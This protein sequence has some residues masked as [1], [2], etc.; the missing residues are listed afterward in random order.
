MKERYIIIVG[1]LFFSLYG[2]NSVNETEIRN[3]YV[4][5]EKDINIENFGEH[6]IKHVNQAKINYN[7]IVKNAALKNETNSAKCYIEENK[8]IKVDINN[9]KGKD[10]PVAIFILYDKFNF[11][12]IHDDLNTILLDN[13]EKEISIKDVQKLMKEES[14]FINKYEIRVIENNG[15]IEIRFF[16]TLIDTEV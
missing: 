4:I 10:Y 13:N 16:V 11:S 8:N 5:C 14:I 15:I 3:R 1:V 12:E 7:K 2:C 9:I 6:A